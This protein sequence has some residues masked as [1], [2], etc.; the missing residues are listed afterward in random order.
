MCFLHY[1]KKEQITKIF[2]TYIRETTKA[3]EAVSVDES[4]VT[5]APNSTAGLDYYDFVEETAAY[6]E[7]APVVEEIIKKN[8][9]ELYGCFGSCHRIWQQREQ[10]LW[11]MYGIEWLSPATLNRAVCFD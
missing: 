9:G 11:D 8:L 1:L 10:L 5:Y 3:K 4:L 6:K 2:N 7:A